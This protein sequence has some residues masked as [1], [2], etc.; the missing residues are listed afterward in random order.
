MSVKKWYEE[1]HMGDHAAHIYRTAAEQGRVIVDVLHWM[2]ESARL[3]LI[4][5]RWDE[6]QTAA[7]SRQ[8]EAAAEEG[9]FVVVPARQSLCPSGRFRPEALQDVIGLERERAASEGFD[10]LV[11][12][13]DLD[14]LCEVPDD[15]DAHIIQQSTQ[16]LSGLPVDLTMMGQYGSTE[17][18]P[19][20]V[21]RVMRVNQ[22]VLEDGTLTRQ[23]WLV[24]NSTMGR[25]PR[26]RGGVSMTWTSEAA[27]TGDL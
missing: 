9:R 27:R 7:R 16:S 15:F 8:L 17:L 12:I 18:S 1:L 3:V 22:L 25:P 21:E 5:D 2:D 20:Q 10:G 26:H 23:F 11:A 4:S 24:A 19:Q 13:W 14:W 6:E